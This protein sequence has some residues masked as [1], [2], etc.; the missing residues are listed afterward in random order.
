MAK[1][2][3][4]EGFKTRLGSV[5]KIKSQKGE[6]V[7]ME[8]G[9][10]I[11]NKKATANNLKRLVEIN[12]DS[13]KKTSAKET[14]DGT[15]GGLL[16]GP[17]HYDKNGKPLGGIKV[18]VDN[19]K[20]IE[21]EGKE[22]AINEEASK[23]HWAE[24][25]K[26]NQSAGN[27]VP[28][29]P[30]NDIDEDPEEFKEGGR[31]IDFNPNRVPSKMIL[32]Y[33]KK[34]KKNYPEVWDLGG[35]IFGNEAFENLKRVSERGYWL[36]SEEW[37][38][39][40]WRSYVAR[41]IH[42]FRIEG[43]IAMLKWVDKVEKGWP[44]MK[45]LIEAE[46]EKR[47]DKKSK[48]GP[49]T[50]KNKYNKK[51]DYEK[52]E[53][54]DLKEISE[55]TGVSIKG[56][57]QIYNK[58]IGAYKTNPKSV[59]PNVKSKEQWATARVYSAVM[60]GKAARVDAK[61]LKMEK[62]G[63]IAPNGNPSNLTPDQYKLV[64][65]SAFKA[66]FGDW[67]NDPKNASKVIDE[68]GEPLV[69]Y[70]GSKSFDIK[71]FDL[72]KSKRK[73]SGLKEF[74][75]YFTD[76]KNLAEAYKNWGELKEK[77]ELEFDSQINKWE[78]I[79]DESRNHRDFEKA[80][81]EIDLLRATKK[82]KVYP[83]FLNLRKVHV[84]DAQGGVNIEAW[85]NLEVK[86][87]Y[88]WASNRDAME[89]LKEGKFGVEKV[90]GIKAEN[91]V[92]A[93]VQ[94]EELKKELLSNVY[95]VFDSK[96]IK[97]ADGTNT[98]F[99]QDNP[100]IRFDKGGLIAPNGKPSNLTPNQYKLVRTPAFKAWFGDWENDPRN[101]SK[102]VDENGEPMVVYRGDSSAS[103]KGN[104]FKTGFNRMGFINKNRLPNQYFHYFV[105][106]FDVALGYA[107]NQIED[108]NDKVEYSG[109]GKL[110]NAEVT[111]YFLNIRNFIDITPSN[112]LFPFFEE[113][114]DDYKKQL[115]EEW[116]KREEYR[117]AHDYGFQISRY[118]LNKLF[119]K[120][121]GKGYLENEERWTPISSWT[122][123]A[124]QVD[125][126]LN[127][128]YSYFIEYKNSYSVSDIL[129]RVYYKMLEKNID[130]LLFL[131]GTH[132]DGGFWGNWKKYESGELTYDYKRW[133][134]KPK[135]FAALESNQI[136]LADGTNT[137][138]DQDNAD[139]R[140]DEGGELDNSKAH[141][142]TSK[143]IEELKKYSV[144]TTSDVMKNAY[145]ETYVYHYYKLKYPHASNW[146]VRLFEKASEEITGKNYHRNFA[147][148]DYSFY[149]DRPELKNRPNGTIQMKQL[150][151]LKMMDGGNID[152]PDSITVDVPLMIRL[153]ESAR[154]DIKSDPELHFVVENLIKLKDKK[155][156]TMDDYAYIVN[157]KKK[158]LNNL[159]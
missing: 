62:G 85:N 61:E 110:W 89:F 43:V 145:G 123:E 21:V 8:T 42:D 111:P 86:A 142:N 57:Q 141:S 84:F 103:K 81:K 14:N 128:T 146:L 96:N 1:T 67:E 154:E 102:V 45:N 65:T 70:H 148:G 23:K 131:E 133:T 32:N 151:V 33:A 157:V 134:E 49:V 91:I 10:T 15:V 156:L 78:K 138:F 39:I 2:N 139:I 97:L 99:D 66:W 64:R 20:E 53:S 4:T 16:E 31:V 29:N 112:P 55:D 6:P 130:G 50:Y 12:N 74:G 25:S 82:G 24:L 104:I 116:Y 69:V 125:K 52:N 115:G 127:D 58:G 71:E 135:V 11:I 83:V 40:K 158:H 153:L 117:M 35:N 140:F 60:G 114:K 155:T 18:I 109:K 38:Y 73:S 63:L 56:L 13:S 7:K 147:T 144:K 122:V 90:D 129:R 95:L 118:H 87:S 30:P 51:Y 80:Q 98:T 105:N 72:S 34:I 54:H 77:E 3:F 132:W 93:Y 46:I 28:I 107:K 108:H 17:A 5:T 152:K 143:L 94:T 19:N 22:F 48:G 27:G 92:D 136:K 75:T 150:E 137:T 44:Y 106:N 79:R 124:F 120:E 26:I 9:Q 119:Q 101:A 47:T 149:Y 121:L 41:H 59:R 159:K 88:K 36:D 113:F 37:M 76:N 100:D 68:N 126:Q